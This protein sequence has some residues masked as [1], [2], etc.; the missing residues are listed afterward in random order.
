MADDQV[1]ASRSSRLASRSAAAMLF[2][3]CGDALGWPVEPRGRRV[4]GTSGL[5]PRLAFIDW[6]RREGGG[7]APFQ[8]L[9]PH[10]TYSDDTQ[11]MLAVARSLTQGKDWRKHLTR[12]ELPALTLYELGGGGAIRSA[13]RSW[14]KGIPPWEAKKSA[15][16]RR[17]F[18]AGANGAAMRILPHAIHGAESE[19]FDGVAE[20]I[21]LDS[22]TTHGHPRAL[23]G[24]L[25]AGYS[26]WTA[27]RWSGK[28]GYGELIEDCLIEQR[29]WSQLPEA[30]L[31]PD[32]LEGAG[33]ALGTEFAEAW[34]RT[35]E[36][37]VGLLDVCRDAMGRGSVARDHDVLDDLGAFGKESGSGVRS[38]AIAIYLASRYIAKPSAGLLAAAFAKRADTDT[39][40]CLT[41]AILGAF[42]GDTRVDG[43]AEDLLDSAYIFDLGTAVANGE[44]RKPHQVEAWEPRMKQEIW[45]RLG[46]VEHGGS[47]TL[48]LFGKSVVMDV[49][50]PATKSSNEIT[51][52]WLRTELGQTLAITR[53]A[54]EQSKAS[55]KA[56]GRG[57]SH[58]DQLAIGEVARE[59]A[60]MPQ[61][62]WTFV[63]VRDLPRAL[64]LYHD[65]LRL[66]VRRQNST[67]AVVGGSLVL[68]QSEI[69][70]T[71][72]GSAD[73]LK[74]PEVIGVLAKPKA[75]DSMHKRVADAGYFVSD[76]ARGRHG[77]RFRLR[78]DDGHVVEVWASPPAS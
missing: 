30:A 31:D 18:N 64:R 22:V 3:A 73:I 48:P 39:I 34:R 21:L 46:E 75:L 7:Y 32:W 19:T 14:S 37:M 58:P 33:E 69:R 25:V 13:C 50:R 17:Y 45:Q 71:R 8:R 78:D 23:M 60:A 65:I 70:E 10:G 47:L 74:A 36:E 55:S 12:F 62:T 42:T 40:A 28:V 61:S 6:R 1:L 26:M 56:S 57:A 38:A 27:L 5:K 15:D 20:H 11:L 35:S 66:P 52:W 77:D 67:M 16:R 51:I 9:I 41:G 76:I 53:T 54:K 44:D 2:A 68:E 24:A 59:D 49:E 43:L 4:G 72:K 63:F 29:A